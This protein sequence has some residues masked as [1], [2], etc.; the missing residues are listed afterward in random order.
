[1]S[2]E[3]YDTSTPIA[4]EKER[5]K[6]DLKEPP[7][8]KVVML[9]DDYTPMDWVVAMLQQFFAKTEDQA[10]AIMMDVHKK[11]KGIAGIYPKDIAETKVAIA[12]QAA[13]QEEYP[14]HL[15]IEVDE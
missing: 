7:R 6:L 8:Y 1:M 10:A 2:D 13:Q 14:F 4:I 15:E 11:G 5:E 3:S 9:N 12:N